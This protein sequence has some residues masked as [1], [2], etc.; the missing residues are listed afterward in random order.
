MID[1]KPPPPTP[2]ELRV[3][4]WGTREITIKDEL[5]N[6]NDL[7]VTC[8]LSVPG[9]KKQE[10]D[11]HWR[12][13]KGKGNFNWRIKF[14]V[15]LPI[16]PWPRLRFQVWDLDIF[17]PNDS[18]CETVMTLKGLCKRAMKKKDR[19]KIYVKGKD[20]FWIDGLRHPNFQGNQG[21]MEIS[22]EIMPLNMAA[23]LPA[24]FGRSDPN[25][26]P[27]LPEPEGR[28]NFS[29]LHPFDMLKEILGPELYR[30]MCLGCC[31]I[32]FTAACVFMAPMIVSNLITN[33]LTPG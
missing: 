25:S 32:L 27:F 3:V 15:N 29:L 4:V 24:G 11:T 18:I 16:K 17:S 8:A 23:Q 22:I 1:I 21:R 13:K 19:V 30:K 5:T 28:I 33:I 9:L 12:S 2:W 26:N 20:R 31:C 10:T 14:P 6:Q 7:F